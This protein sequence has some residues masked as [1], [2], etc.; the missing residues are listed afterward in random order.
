MIAPLTAKPLCFW[1]VKKQGEASLQEPSFLKKQKA[2]LK[3]PI[4]LQA[5]LPTLSIKILQ[6]VGTAQA[7]KGKL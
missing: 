7:S 4:I 5:S 1:E 3:H 2:L 6:Q